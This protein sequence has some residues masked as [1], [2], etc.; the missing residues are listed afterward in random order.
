MAVAISLAIKA[1]KF[2][3]LVSTHVQY[4]ELVEA[5]PLHRKIHQER[6]DRDLLDEYWNDDLG[7]QFSE[8]FKRI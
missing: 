7:S 1:T 2:A 8:L 3:S 4:L 6:L 5:G